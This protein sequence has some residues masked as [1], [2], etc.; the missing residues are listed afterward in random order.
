MRT[1]KQRRTYTFLY[2]ARVRAAPGPHVRVSPAREWV[3]PGPWVMRPVCRECS[4][5]RAPPSG[6]AGRVG[7]EGRVRLCETPKVP[8]RAVALVR[9]PAG[10]AAAGAADVCRAVHGRGGAWLPSPAPRRRGREHPTRSLGSRRHPCGTS[11]VFRPSRKLGCPRVLGAS[12]FSG[13]ESLI[14]NAI[15]TCFLPAWFAFMPPRQ[16]RSQDVSC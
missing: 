16:C 11:R 9:A 8:P 13:Y 3:L 10:P 15:P 6:C 1:S 2:L 14:R 12:A 4:R 5:G 7:S